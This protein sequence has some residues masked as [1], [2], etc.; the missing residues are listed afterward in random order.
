[1]RAATVITRLEG[2]AGA[3]LL[4]GAR[5]LNQDAFEMVVI[6]PSGSDW[7]LAEALR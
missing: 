5:E 7:L 4:C 6:T 2:G 1:M 3:Q